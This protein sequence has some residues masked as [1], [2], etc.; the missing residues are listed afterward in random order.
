[1]GQEC[2]RLDRVD[3]TASS[4]AGDRCTDA[5]LVKEYVMIHLAILLAIVALVAGGLG[6]TGIAGAAASGARLVF[7]L[8]LVLLIVAIGMIALGASLF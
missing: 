5:A 2:G 8:F 6:F 7:G 4:V 3:V 1:V